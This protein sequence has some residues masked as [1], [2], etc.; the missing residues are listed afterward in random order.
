[1]DSTDEQ[2]QELRNRIREIRTARKWLQSYQ[3]EAPVQISAALGAFQKWLI[4]QEEKTE[5]LGRR[6]K[7]Q[8]GNNNR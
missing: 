2:L 4:E 3:I 6:I 7:A 8:Q 1:M 5:R